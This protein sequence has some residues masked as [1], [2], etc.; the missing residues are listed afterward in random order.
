LAF[1]KDLASSVQ[2]HRETGFAGIRRT[3]RITS[4]PVMAPSPLN[5]LTNPFFFQGPV[6]ARTTEECSKDSILRR[7]F[8]DALGSEPSWTIE[9]T[10][11]IAEAD[12]GLNG[13]GP[14]VTERT[15]NPPKRFRRINQRF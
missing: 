4:R 14:S 9:V 2:D 6:T 13:V 12:R 5:A 10:G 3:Q 1:F 8:L 11:E 7:V 15:R